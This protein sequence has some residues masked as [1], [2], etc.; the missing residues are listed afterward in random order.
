MTDQTKIIDIELPLH[1]ISQTNIDS[2]CLFLKIN[3]SPE[4]D[5]IRI[6]NLLTQ[7]SFDYFTQHKRF[8]S[9][10]FLLNGTWGSGKTW[11][12]KVYEQWLQRLTK[13][14]YDNIPFVYTINTKTKTEYCNFK[15]DEIKLLSFSAWQYLEEKELFFDLW[16]ELNKSLLEN[17]EDFFKDP[18]SKEQI[19][20]KAKVVGI[21]I[22]LKKAPAIGKYIFDHFITLAGKAVSPL[23]PEIIQITNNV[24]NSVKYE[25]EISNFLLMNS[26]RELQLAIKKP[27]II[28]IDD[29]DRVSEEKLWR[30]LSLLSLFD[31]QDNLLFIC[32]GSS[33]FLI[34]ILE[35]KYHVKGE[36]ENF[37]T[38]FFAKEFELETPDY[39]D[40]LIRDFITDETERLEIYNFLNLFV[41]IKTYREYKVKYKQLLEEWIDG[42]EKTKEE[43]TAKIVNIYLKL[44]HS[45][46]R[47]AIIQES[48]ISS[49]VFSSAF[50]SILNDLTKETPTHKQE[51]T[52]SF[53]IHV[54][55]RKGGRIQDTNT[56]IQ[57]IRRRI[58]ETDLQSKNK[59]GEIDRWLFEDIT[60]YII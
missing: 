29:L 3:S 59:A 6:I 11:T 2:I 52:Y 16:R 4:V 28:V 32:V 50:E 19:V 21:D 35:K 56:K 57:E 22:F 38:K 13:E 55:I 53:V 45:I 40:L 42:V 8:E 49:D 31:K 9:N 24:T 39:L 46:F 15:S 51:N 30:I 44:K 60:K 17:L 54:F 26:N 1:Q 33:K 27:T 48:K 12:I 18:R 47:E 41:E 25:T 36:G 14:K 34:E 23:K 37:L 20:E 58:K 5:R 7:N 43:I 10:C